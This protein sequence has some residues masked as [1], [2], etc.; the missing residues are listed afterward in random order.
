L[1]HIGHRYGWADDLDPSRR[2][3]TYHY[4]QELT[5]PD[6]GRAVRW[7]NIGKFI[8]FGAA[9]KIFRVHPGTISGKDLSI[10]LGEK[11]GPLRTFVGQTDL[12]KYDGRSFKHLLG[13]D[14]NWNKFLSKGPN[15]HPVTK[16]CSDFAFWFVRRML[17]RE[18]QKLQESQPATMIEEWLLQ[19]EEWQLSQIEEWLLHLKSS[20]P[21]EKARALQSAWELG[22]FALGLF[23]NRE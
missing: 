9:K 21:E 18:R 20:F 4:C 15:Y 12:P 11:D 8:D 22:K 19:I 3:I 5:F 14:K 7:A 1:P 23:G 17:Q 6:T 10:I 2:D 13:I 16:N